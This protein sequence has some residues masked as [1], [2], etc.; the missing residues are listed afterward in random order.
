[1]G[2][3]ARQ[4]RQQVAPR[5]WFTETDRLR[6]FRSRMGSQQTSL[7]LLSNWHHLEESQ[8]TWLAS[9]TWSTEVRISW[10]VW[11]LGREQKRLHLLPIWSVAKETSRNTL[12]S[13]WWKTEANRERT[14]WSCLWCKQTP[15]A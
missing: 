4:S 6:S 3:T 13:H 11:S 10:T 15:P 7:H 1:M 8:G 14:K 2:I 9:R 5:R 12:A